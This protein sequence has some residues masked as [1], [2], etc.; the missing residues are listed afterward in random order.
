[1]LRDLVTSSWKFRQKK[2]A[3]FPSLIHVIGEVT[4]DGK[5][6]YGDTVITEAEAVEAWKGTLERVFKTVS[7]EEN[8]KP[9]KDA[10][11][12]CRKHLC[13]QTQSCKTACIYSGI[14]GNQLRIR[15][16]TRI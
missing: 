14:P 9:A 2:S 13:M 12:P 10:A 7:G 3:N 15:Q 4:E 5:F 16:H 11:V 8:E 1:M 6:S